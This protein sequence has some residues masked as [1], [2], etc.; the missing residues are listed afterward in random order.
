MRVSYI[1]RLKNA[2][3]SATNENLNQSVTNI[4]HN[5]LNLA[6]YATGNNSIITIELDTT[7]DIDH[8]AFDYHNIDTMIIKFYDVFDVLITTEIIT[9]LENCN[10]HYFNTVEN[11][12]SI[13]ITLTTVATLLYIG[14]ISMGEYFELP[15]FQQSP[16]GELQLTDTYST[17]PGGQRTGNRRFCPL[18]KVLNYVNISRQEKDDI[19]TYLRYM[20]NSI[21]HFIDFYPD[22][23]DEESPIWGACE[24]NGSPVPKRI[25]SDFRYDLSIT[26]KECK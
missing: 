26:Y 17:S 20:Q 9:V 21:P 3:L 19:I 12:S 8:I 23:H 22:A 1:N 14:G 6:F 18:T 7:Y 24:M 11:V 2:T 16:G 10:F 5:F 25:L 4:I 13:T 15:N